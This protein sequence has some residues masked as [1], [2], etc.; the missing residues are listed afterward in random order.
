MPFDVFG[1][2]KKV[3]SERAIVSFLHILMKRIEGDYFQLVFISPDT[4]Q[5]PL[6][7]IF[8]NCPQ[9]WTQEYSE[10]NMLSVDPIVYRGL[11]QTS[12]ILW[13]K[14]F[15]ECNNDGNLNELEVILLAQNVGILDG[16]TIPWHGANGHIGLLSIMTRSIRDDNYW[17]AAMPSLHWLSLNLCETIVCHSLLNKAAHEKLS[18]RELEVCQWAAEGKQVSDI[19]QILD[20]AP[21]TVSFHL[22]RATKKFGATSKCQMISRAIKQGVVRLNVAMAL[23]SNFIDGSHDL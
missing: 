23:V 14:V 7:R 18:L 16:V 21:R 19:A 15:D 22:E 9:A 20:I 12:P 17:V 6:V 2:L 13:R 11:G 3:D 1:Q 5:R 4:I 8:N 10:R